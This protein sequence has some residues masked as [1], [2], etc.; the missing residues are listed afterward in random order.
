MKKALLSLVLI[1]WLPFSCLANQSG[2]AA[3]FIAGAIG[4]GVTAGY[5][6]YLGRLPDELSDWADPRTQVT[7]R[8][9]EQCGVLTEMKLIRTGLTNYLFLG[10][11]NESKSDVVV[12][13][14]RIQ[15]K[16]QNG[17]ERYLLAPPRQRAQEIKKNW[18]SWGFLAFPRKNDFKGQTQVEIIIPVLVNNETPCE[19]KAI[20]HRDM[21][22][23]EEIASF[24]EAPSIVASMGMST[25]ALRIGQTERTLSPLGFGFD[26][27]VAGF[28]KPESGWYLQ[29]S[30]FTFGKLKNATFYGNPGYNHVGLVDLSIGK[31]WRFFHSENKTSY[32]NLGPSFAVFMANNPQKEDL[33]N[34]TSKGALGIYASYTYEWR[35]SRTYHGFFHGDRS[36]GMTLFLKYLPYVYQDSPHD[37]GLAGVS[38]E[39][40]RFGE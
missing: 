8:L 27:Y 11:R 30:F 19:L 29:S 16:F 23:S 7:S 22:K 9:S 1:F 31:A 12:Q 26:L 38:F 24:I 33:K 35:Y 15:A 6:G 14:D 21:S 20:F 36:I 17:R 25:E 5:Q 18:Y 39:F 4:G 10:V 13:L 37:A 32:L 2:V 34:G 3:A 28:K 40:L